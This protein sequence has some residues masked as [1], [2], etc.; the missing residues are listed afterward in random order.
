MS[1]HT[2]LEVASRMRS[3]GVFKKF[4][5]Y[6]RFPHLKNFEDNLRINFNS[7]I[8]FLVGP[9]GTGKSSI[10]Q[11]LYGCPEGKSLGNYWFN[12]QLDP[13]SDKHFFI[14]SYITEK[15]N[16]QVEVIKQRVHDPSN[17]DYWEP[18]RPNKKFGMKEVPINADPDEAHKTRWKLLE[19]EV[20]YL[21]FRYELS[22][23]DKY[24]YFG[25]RP[26]TVT[27]KTKQDLIR[28]YAARLA[29]SYSKNCETSFRSLKASKPISLGN[30]E[31]KIISEILGKNYKEAKLLVHNYY[32]RMGGHS[33]Y[34]KTKNNQNY[35]EA[36]AG[37]GEIA[38]VKLIHEIYNANNYTLV[39]LD[40]PETSLHPAAQ[41]K[42]IKFLINQIVKKKLQV[43]VST[44]SS[45]LIENMP[46]ESIKVLY[47]REDNSKVD[48]IENVLPQEAFYHIGHSLSNKTQ[49][50]VEDK[51][52]KLILERSILK[53]GGEALANLFEVKFFP[54]GETRLKLDFLPTYSRDGN[55]THFIIFDGDMKVDKV[56]VGDL[57][58]NQKNEEYLGQIITNILKMDCKRISFAQDSGRSEQKIEQM[59]SLIKFH[60]ERVFYLPKSIPEKIIWSKKVLKKT[61]L[62]RKEKEEILEVLE[63]KEANDTT[64]YKEV[65]RLVAKYMFD[66][67]T[68][69]G[70][71]QA[72]NYFLRRWIKKDKKSNREINSIIETI[73][74]KFDVETL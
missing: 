66:D 5:E 74:T 12:T 62:S 60:K 32:K 34:Y 49:L 36:F 13:I 26:N 1:L 55:K 53:Y 52:A 4:I 16:T 37:S 48:V 41:K 54:G 65:F 23:Y 14:Y 43:V 47:E 20:L 7:P 19:R 11:A 30:E 58:D 45:D 40:E 10:L 28:R 3:R 72:H 35:S 68:A 50:I 31:L 44:H 42:L 21:D 6:I 51:L 29:Q 15:T 2:D 25:E 18:A 69:R 59:L 46:K 70:I 22:A 27:M 39:L 24:F 63:D 61:D 9:N 71:E 67:E 56:E 73:T 8:T 33:V 17:P 38:V 57:S 64:I